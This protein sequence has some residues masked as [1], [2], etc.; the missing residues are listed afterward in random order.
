MKNVNL[1]KNIDTKNFHHSETFFIK[2]SS[3]RNKKI[4]KFSINHKTQLDKNFL[5]KDKFFYKEC[6]NL[7]LQILKQ[8]PKNKLFL[9][10]SVINMYKICLKNIFYPN[11]SYIKIIKLLKIELETL[12]LNR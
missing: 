6:G 4:E 2:K 7:M 8:K 1:L 3:K 12:K 10:N 11:F 9:K 5:S